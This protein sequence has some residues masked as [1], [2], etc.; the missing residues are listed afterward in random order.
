[1]GATRVQT[2]PA[3]PLKRFGLGIN[4]LAR[5][6][7]QVCGF[8]VNRRGLDYFFQLKLVKAVLR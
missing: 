7:A 1:M 3:Y 8:R 5:W 6:P 2:E 4:E